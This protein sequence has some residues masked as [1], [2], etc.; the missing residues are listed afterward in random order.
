M[1]RRDRTTD[2]RVDIG[3]ITLPASYDA[4]DLATRIEREI[5]DRRFGPGRD[6]VVT[7]LAAR[8][9]SAVESMEDIE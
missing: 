7:A 3:S 8:L 6:P 1:N 2:L 9:A 5:A 4:R